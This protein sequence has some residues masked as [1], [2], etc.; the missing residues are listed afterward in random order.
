[1]PTGAEP[2]P[3]KGTEPKRELVVRRWHL[4][5]KGETR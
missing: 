2:A 1:M 4:S 5:D 3:R